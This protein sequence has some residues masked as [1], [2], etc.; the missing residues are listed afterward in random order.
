M[1]TNVHEEVDRLTQHGHT[2]L[3]E[4][5]IDDACSAFERAAA[6][7][8]HIEEGY[9]ERACY[10]NLG[11]CYVAQGDA[12]KGLEY[13]KKAVPP[14]KDSDGCANYA[15]L[16]YNLGLAYDALNLLQSGVECYETALMEYKNQNNQ[17]MQAETLNKLAV[18]CSA[19]GEAKK[20]A[21]YFGDAAGVYKGLG[22]K[23]NEVLALTSR[24]SLLGL[25]KEIDECAKTLT[26]VIEQCEDL[27]DQTLQG[28]IYNDLG[29]L[30]NGLKSYKHAAEC[31]EIA[32]PLI[33]GAS[34][35]KELEA[36]L[37]QN[38]GAVYNQLGQYRKAL[39]HHKIAGKLHGELGSRSAEG[40]T[41]CNMG[42][43]YSQLKDYE[44]AK[45]RFSQAIQASIDTNDTRSHWQASEGLAAV[46]FLQGNYKKAVE[47]YKIALGLLSS[48]G[49]IT[50][51]HNERIVNKLAD[52]MKFQLAQGKS[53]NWQKNSSYRRSKGSKK[54]PQNGKDE[55]DM[56]KS[57]KRVGKTRLR[58]ENHRLIAH[59]LAGHD[60][61]ESDEPDSSSNSSD[62]ESDAEF[63]GE[64]ARYVS[65]PKEKKRRERREKKNLTG[66]RPELLLSGPYQKLIK[67]RRSSA[68]DNNEA[69]EEP[70]DDNVAPS[71]SKER[72]PKA[73]YSVE[74]PRAYREAYLAS[75]ANS[76]PEHSREVKR[77]SLDKQPHTTKSKTCVIQ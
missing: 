57:Y 64:Q 24:A 18:D 33:S 43:A 16:H 72:I 50:A 2:C 30:Y 54:S 8:S 58:K 59:G 65:T 74:M 4:G 75:I 6:L 11:A 36:V 28:K 9:T 31:F 52:A 51:E 15:D 26:L 56:E 41:F 70:V 17:E 23:K 55:L 20:A 5:N 7:S 66:S 61:T 63:K 22:D 38:L 77:V 48:S 60:I 14:D 29:L 71:P 68:D 53:D 19:I 13:L 34:Q 21:D 73:D 1:G 40:Q 69:Y 67:N 42:F 76:S 10:F 37:R 27:T 39:Q 62:S 25:L 3:S 47:N 12:R 46:Y 44:N 45:D 35:E 32:I 49:D